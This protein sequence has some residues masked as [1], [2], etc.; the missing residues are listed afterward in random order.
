MRQKFSPS[1]LADFEQPQYGIAMGGGYY[2]YES[3]KG[4]RETDHVVVED[5][6]QRLQEAVRDLPEVSIEKNRPLPK[7]ART[8][9]HNLGY[10]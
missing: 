4:F 7:E 6:E 2:G 9:L 1:I 3:R 5:G 10:M 8:Q